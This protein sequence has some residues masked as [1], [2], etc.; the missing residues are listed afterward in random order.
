MSTLCLE[1]NRG[2]ISSPEREPLLDNS[3]DRHLR[4]ATG[5]AVAFAEDPHGSGAIVN[6]KNTSSRGPKGIGNPSRDRDLFAGKSGRILVDLG[7]ALAPRT[8][9]H[10]ETCHAYQHYAKESGTH[11][12]HTILPRQLNTKVANCKPSPV[13]DL[14]TLWSPT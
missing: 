6:L 7:N 1:Q 2:E 13:C 11:S 12:R 4:A 8:S 14:P 10:E 3:G 5:N 9:R